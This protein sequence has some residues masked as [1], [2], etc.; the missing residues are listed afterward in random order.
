VEEKVSTWT[1]EL[2][3]LSQIAPRS[4]LCLRPR[5]ETQMDLP[6]AYPTKHS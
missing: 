5:N 3:T 2:N 4:T 1:E 6:S